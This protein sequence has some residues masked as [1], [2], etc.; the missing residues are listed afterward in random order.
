MIAG[1]LLNM[2]GNSLDYSQLRLSSSVA[3][4]EDLVNDT[5]VLGD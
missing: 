4:C 2:T 5:E 1:V 3:T